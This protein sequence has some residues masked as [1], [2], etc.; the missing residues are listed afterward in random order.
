IVQ[1]AGNAV[2]YGYDEAATSDGGVGTFPEEE[3]GRAALRRS[4][5]TPFLNL[6]RIW[7]IS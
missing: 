3:R 4:G 2:R 7:P 5:Q 6:R 1:R